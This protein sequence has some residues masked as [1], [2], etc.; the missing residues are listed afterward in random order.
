M[1]T[2]EQ[3]LTI[4]LQ[5]DENTWFAD[6]PV[7]V[8]LFVVSNDKTTILG[9]AYVAVASMWKVSSL[10]LYHTVVHYK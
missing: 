8:A 10:N 2:L 1:Y 9:S 6:C 5:V 4:S 3:R 7:P